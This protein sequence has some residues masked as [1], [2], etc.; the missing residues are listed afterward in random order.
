MASLAQVGSA[1]EK[2]H[3]ANDAVNGQILADEYR[4]LQ[5]VGSQEPAKDPND[6]GIE[7]VFG[8][9]N[10]GQTAGAVVRVLA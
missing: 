3:A 4:R 5:A 1:L 10:I 6:A 7:N 9:S 8:E 2:A